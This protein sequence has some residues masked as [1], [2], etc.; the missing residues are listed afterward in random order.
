M[1]GGLKYG[2]EAAPAATGSRVIMSGTG[3]LA[4]KVH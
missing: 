1:P 2:P 3:A 4:P